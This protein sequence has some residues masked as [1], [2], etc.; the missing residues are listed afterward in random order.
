MQAKE[1][2]S[3]LA[4]LFEHLPI[5]IVEMGTSV[6][7]ISRELKKEKLIKSLIE[8]LDELNEN[9]SV[10]KS[11]I[12]LIYYIGDEGPTEKVFRFLNQVQS[13]QSSV[14]K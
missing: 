6:Q 8:K 12:D 10:S 3:Q 14:Q 7:V 1:L 9:K 5:E 13:K 4:N 11:P 2:I